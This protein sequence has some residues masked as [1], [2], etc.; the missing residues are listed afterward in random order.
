[1]SS[2]AASGAPSEPYVGDPPM[3]PWWYHP[4]IG[5]LNGG[6]VAFVVTRSFPVMIIVLAG[7]GVGLTILSLV[8]PGPTGLPIR[9]ARATSPSK[10]L[11]A[12]R[13][14]TVLASA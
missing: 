6:L 13:L 8:H 4:A 12:W 9:G 14:A 1:M 2:K 5:V 7:F 11:T 10:W 3:T